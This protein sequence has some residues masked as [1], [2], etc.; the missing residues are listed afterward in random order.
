M[1]SAVTHFVCRWSLLAGTAAAIKNAHKT[2]RHHSPDRNEEARVIE[3]RCSYTSTADKGGD[4]V[5]MNILFCGD[6]HMTDGVLLDTLS[7]MRTTREPLHIFVLTATLTVNEL[8]YKPFPV[9]TAA[10][11]TQL[12][13]K[14]NPVQLYSRIDITNLFEDNPPREYSNT[15]FTPYCML[16]LYADLVPQLPDRMLY[17]DTDDFCRRPF[18]AFYHES[19][20]GVD[21][22]GALDQVGQW[23][24]LLRLMWFD[25]RLSGVLLMNLE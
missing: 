3:T 4:T 14:E 13:T 20:T 25:Y 12:M 23:W 6:A 24:L 1:A 18:A 10:T 9:A 2:V 17:L 8:R 19:M 11:M 16:R 21:I 5:T 22:A 15:M 7:L